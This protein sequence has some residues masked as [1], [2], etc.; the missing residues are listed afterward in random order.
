MVPRV[1]RKQVLVQLDDA[2]VA[3]LDRLADASDDTRSGLIRRAID[4][5]LQ[6]VDE[7]LTDLRYAEAYQRFPEDLQELAE[8]QSLAALAWPEP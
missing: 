5:F 7:G 4:L 1:T 8:L 3:A 2:E 6:A